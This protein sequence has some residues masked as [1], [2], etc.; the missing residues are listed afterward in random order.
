MVYLQ[1][2][3]VSTGIH[4]SLKLG[5][6]INVRVCGNCQCYARFDSKA[7]RVMQMGTDSD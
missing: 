4:P 6:S 2:F 3:R 5:V 1:M 7:D